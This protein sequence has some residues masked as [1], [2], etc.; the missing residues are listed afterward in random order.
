MAVGQQFRKLKHLELNE[1]KKN[2]HAEAAVEETKSQMDLLRQA[3]VIDSGA[4]G[5]SVMLEAA[6]NCVESDEKFKIVSFLAFL[7]LS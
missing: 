6:Y 4:Y 7:K 2:K 5:F 1:D 3:D